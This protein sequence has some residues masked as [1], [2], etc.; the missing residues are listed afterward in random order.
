MI[1]VLNICENLFGKTITL[2]L[3]TLDTVATIKVLIQIKVGISMSQ[4]RLIFI[5]KHIEGGYSHHI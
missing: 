5:G 3:G 1:N 2:E 4:Q